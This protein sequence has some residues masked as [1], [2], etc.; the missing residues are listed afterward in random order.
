MKKCEH[1][2]LLGLVVVTTNSEDI[3]GIIIKPISLVSG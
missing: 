2:K 3:N 1:N